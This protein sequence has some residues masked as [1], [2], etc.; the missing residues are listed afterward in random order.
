MKKTLL[1]FTF[2]AITMSLSAQITLERS[3]YTRVAGQDINGWEINTAS[4]TLPTEGEAQTWDYSSME[5]TTPYSYARAT[6]SHPDLPEVNLSATSTVLQLGLI[7]QTYTFYEV[8]DDDEYSTVARLSTLG[9]SSLEVLSGNPNDTLTLTG[10]FNIYPEPLYFYQFPVNFGDSYTTNN[11][12]VTE[13]ELTVEGFGIDHV[14]G[15]RTFYSTR[16]NSIV[17]YGTLILPHP[18]GTGSISIEALLQ[19]KENMAIDSTFLG[20][21]P[22]PPELLAAFGLQQGTVTTSS[23]YTFIAKNLPRSAFEIEFN[24][25]TVSRA[26]MSDDVKDLMSSIYPVVE[27]LLPVTVSPNP[28]TGVFQLDFEKRDA[29][30]WQLSVFNSLG[31]LVE[32]QVLNAAV[33]S[34]SITIS[35]PSYITSGL[36]HFTIENEKG[37]LVGTDKF[38]INK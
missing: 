2:I 17:G 3:D 21:Q 16:T 33:G 28:S 10:E 8:L 9:S 12:Y 19:K 14:P 18:D 32:Q 27:N 35:L 25:G 4:V 31:Q 24:D 5:L 11:V 6:A 34:H 37:Q 38:L 29:A 26:T 15:N 13:T 30:D 20:G 7:P 23:D 22:A 1:L 36:Y